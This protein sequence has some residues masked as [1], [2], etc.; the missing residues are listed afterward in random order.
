MEYCNVAALFTLPLMSSPSLA[1]CA[2]ASCSGAGIG[3][4]GS[5]AFA[6]CAFA[7]APFFFAA[8]AGFA[9]GAL[10]LAAAAGF[11]LSAAVVVLALA[12]APGLDSETWVDGAAS[13]FTGLAAARICSSV[14]SF[15]SNA[16]AAA[17]GATVTS[18]FTGANPVI[19]IV[20]VHFPSARSA[21]E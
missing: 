20:I 2:V 18:C 19:S 14:S 10:W 16:P 5:G 7:A 4:A 21:K 15:I 17:L 13:S 12:G 11:V 6:S 9:V 8:A 3:A 1:C